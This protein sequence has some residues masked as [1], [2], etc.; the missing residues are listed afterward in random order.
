MK[1]PVVLACIL[2]ILVTAVAL[3]GCGSGDSSSESPEEVAKAFF[4]A[5]GSKDAD[6]VW[7]LLSANTK[8]QAGTE[9]KAELEKYF[10]ELDSIEFTV[11]K[12]TVDGDKAT[13]EVTAT[14]SGE[15]S[16]EDIPLVKEDGVWKVDMASSGSTTE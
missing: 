1:K 3:V 6:T 2:L 11:G 12:V 5:Y 8:E 13:A 4:A 14:V 9:G 15:E 10:E 7:S 16:T